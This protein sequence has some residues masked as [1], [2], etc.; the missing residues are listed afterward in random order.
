MCGKLLVL[1]VLVGGFI[2]SSGCSDLLGPP[3]SG[4]SGSGAV[5]TPTP[6]PNP[7]YGIGDIVMKNP[8][9]RIGEVVQNFDPAGKTYST[10]SV[11]LGDFGEV[12][13]YV[14]GGSKSFSLKDFEAQYPYKR[15]TVDNPYNL[16]LPT[17]EYT[18]KYGVNQVVT[19]KNVPLEGIKILSYDYPRD[20]YTY[21]YVYKQGSTWVSR[22]NITYTGARTDVE[23]RYAEKN[24]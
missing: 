20:A 18:P 4:G 7:K 21:M 15:G 24:T 16:P 2:L 9:D 19:K 14:G 12:S 17:R 5:T 8:D 13:F 1:F 3:G 22:D 23:E 6:A 10:R 11:I